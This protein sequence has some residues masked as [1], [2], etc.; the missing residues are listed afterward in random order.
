MNNE[1]PL[2]NNP[3]SEL[4]PVPA[5]IQPEPQEVPSQV[6]QQQPAEPYLS[7]Q[8]PE[9]LPIQQP[10][11]VQSPLSQPQPQFS[12]TAPLPADPN[13]R[14]F[15]PF[16]FG[17]VGLF[18]AVV[19][20]VMAFTF[21]VPNQ[22]DYNAAIDSYNDVADANNKLISDLD[23]ITIG[24]APETKTKIEKDYSSYKE[25][26]A[27]LKDLKALRDGETNKAYTSLSKKNDEYTKYFDGILASY[28]DMMKVS[29]DCSE[30]ASTATQQSDDINQ[31]VSD[32]DAAIQPCRDSLERLQASDNELIADY[33]KDTLSFIDDLRTMLQDMVSAVLARNQTAY[34]AAEGEYALL[35]QEF[36]G[37]VEKFEKDMEKEGDN[38]SVKKAA[39]NFKDILEKK[40]ENSIF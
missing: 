9:E 8:T 4:E 23:S 7:A 29:K 24:D 14:N 17:G 30:D 35:V 33:G 38:K 26:F 13:T 1:D 25:A 36:T 31:V 32:F 10:V 22:A 6:P 37:V 28:D 27:K 40:A 18:V 39:D 20:G 15:K 12:E 3:G 5:N 19:L 16:I 34:L 21:F 2:T 11:A